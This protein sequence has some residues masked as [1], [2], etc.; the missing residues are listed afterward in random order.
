V[1][2]EVGD[3][4]LYYVPMTLVGE[5][6]E[7]P[8][9]VQLGKGCRWWAVTPDGRR[10]PLTA[11]SNRAAITCRWNRMNTRSVGSRIRIVPAQ[12]SGMSVA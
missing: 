8:S 7:A 11:P 9:V 2:D 12:R 4:G 3:E 10:Q 1:L 5:P 6:V